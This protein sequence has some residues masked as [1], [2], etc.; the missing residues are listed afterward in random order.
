MNRFAFIALGL[1]ASVY[2]A[3][4]KT[5][6]TAPKEKIDLGLGSFNSLPTTEGLSKPTDKR[7]SDEPTTKPSTVT[8]T[9]VQVVHGKSFTHSPDGAKASAPYPEVQASGDPLTAEKFSSI[10]RVKCPQKQNAP[11]DVAILDARGNT[12]LESSG[13]LI[14]R[15]TKKDELDY[16]I[17]WAPTPI[18]SGGDYKVLVRINGEPM[19]TF[20]LKFAE[21]K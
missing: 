1:A 13:T 3:P 15:G 17:D 10:V 20:P 19:G 14:F 12:A 2:A 11:I 4:P 9:V 18:R 21:K 16:Q 8:Y 6:S 5:K 7:A